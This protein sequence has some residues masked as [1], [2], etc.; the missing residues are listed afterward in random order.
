MVSPTRCD[1]GRAG[2]GISVHPGR[3]YSARPKG[4]MVHE[5]VQLYSGRRS[6]WDLKPDIWSQG[7]PTTATQTETS[8]QVQA[9]LQ[10]AERHAQDKLRQGHTEGLMTCVERDCG[11]PPGHQGSRFEE[12]IFQR[13][14]TRWARG[15]ALQ[16]GPM[17]VGLGHPGKERGHGQ[18]APRPLCSPGHS[19]DEGLRAFPCATPSLLPELH[20]ML[21]SLIYF[22][23]PDVLGTE[24][25]VVAVWWLIIKDTVLG[26]GS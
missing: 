7:R 24:P 2:Q 8:T 6:S 18:L 3:A 10:T 4:E 9:W 1:E 20:R 26:P 25:S 15:A 14:P 19:P 13:S 12:G 22:F 21:T 5:G 17:R 23:L 11:C 16:K